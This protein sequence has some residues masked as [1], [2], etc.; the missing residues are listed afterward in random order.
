MLDRIDELILQCSS[1]MRAL[2]HLYLAFKNDVIALS[3]SIVK[4]KENTEDALQETFIR[5][6][7]LAAHYK[8]N[9][10]GKVYILKIASNVA[11][12]IYRKDK[13]ISLLGEI[14]IIN[15][16]NEYA[17]AEAAVVVEQLMAQLKPQERELITLR[18]YSD[19][20]LRETAEVLGKPV[21]SVQWKLESIYA[22]L[23]NN[24]I[25]I[26]VDE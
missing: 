15:P 17:R 1:D 9:G 20:T 22:K 23:R 2:E 10:R 13:H 4:T 16:I 11:H 18:F 25:D 5:L 24:G 19:L 12:E 3:R 7:T 14:D 6:K 26:E 8:P 21:S